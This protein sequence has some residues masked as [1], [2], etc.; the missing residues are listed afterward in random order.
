MEYITISPLPRTTLAR[1]R[2][3]AR[4]TST[5]NMTVADAVPSSTPDPGVAQQVLKG[6]L[7]TVGVY[8]LVAFNAAV[9][10]AAVWYFLSWGKDWVRRR[11]ERASG[12]VV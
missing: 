2:L 9:L 8:V 6:E 4:A 10:G 7:I 12:S 1:S 5:I 3:L 11:R